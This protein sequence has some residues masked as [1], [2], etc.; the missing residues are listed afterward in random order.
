MM[1]NERINP[2]ENILPL[3]V[4]ERYI[5]FEYRSRRIFSHRTVE[6]WPP[7]PVNARCA[8]NSEAFDTKEPSPLFFNWANTTLTE[9][10]Y[11]FWC[12]RRIIDHF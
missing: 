3:E 1:A 10:R 4:K 8:R 2:E 11:F 6:K 5:E 7:Q 12:W 9:L